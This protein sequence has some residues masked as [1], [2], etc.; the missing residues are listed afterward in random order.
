MDEGD[1]YALILGA[2]YLTGLLIGLQFSPGVIATV[3][4]AF[5]LC[6]MAIAVYHQRSGPQF[7]KRFLTA[8]IM[9]FVANTV[10]VAVVIYFS[11]P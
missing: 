5:I 6:T 9:S 2:L 7:T 3:M 4:V 1:H 10:G 11:T 8:S